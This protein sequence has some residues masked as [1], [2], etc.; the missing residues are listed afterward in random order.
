MMCIRCQKTEAPEP[1]GLCAV[2]AVHLRVELSAGFSRLTTYLTA[3]AAFDA[4]LRA[5][6][7]GGAFA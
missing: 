2:C 7:R 1:L 3:W 4:W 6:D 5:R